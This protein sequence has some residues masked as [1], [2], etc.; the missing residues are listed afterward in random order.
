GGVCRGRGFL[1]DGGAG[2]LLVGDG[3]AVGAGGEERGGGEAVDYAGE[4]CLD[5]E[6]LEVPSARPSGT[7]RA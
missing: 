7:E 3:L 2:G 6:V 5:L 4:G 1:G